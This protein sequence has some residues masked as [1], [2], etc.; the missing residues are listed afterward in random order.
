MRFARQSILAAIVAAPFFV[1]SL[2]GQIR[3]RPLIQ[4][5]RP[6]RF[7]I[8][9]GLLF[10]QPKGELA[11]NIDNGIGGDI[12][13]MFRLDPEGVVSL[14]VDGGGLQYGREIIPAPSVFGGRVG[15]QVETSNSIFWGAIGPQVMIPLGRLRPYGSVQIGVM[16]FTTRSSVQGTGDYQGETFASTENQNDATNTWIFGGGM[17]VPFS[18]RLR[19][20]SIDVGGKYFTGGHAT[21]LREG[22]IRDNSDG[23]IT[24]FPSNS[25]TDQIT[26]HIGVAYTIPRSIRR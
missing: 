3:S 5:E 7:T 19:M 8:G 1:S 23:T 25:K 15:F 21:Y 10:S 9:G 22:A 11:E 16:D 26:W 4:V 6:S 12:Y 18:G 13:G 14:R 20:L 17:Y 24:L 2:Q